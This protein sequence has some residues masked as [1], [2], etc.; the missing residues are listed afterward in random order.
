MHSDSGDADGERAIENLK[1]LVAALLR[2]I[3][4]PLPPTLSDDIYRYVWDGKVIG[5][6]LNPYLLAPQAADLEPLR[7][8]LWDR[9]PHREVETVYPPV[10]LRRLIQRLSGSS[11]R[12][13]S[14]T[15]ERAPCT[16]KLRR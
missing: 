5:A 4:L 1:E 13:A 10:A 16:S 14:L 8:E 12:A 3:A 9:L 11:F 6:G 15:R 2:V 7:D